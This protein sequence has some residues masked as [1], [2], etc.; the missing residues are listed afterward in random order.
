MISSSKEYVAPSW[1]WNSV[2]QSSSNSTNNNTDE[3]QE[4][5]E[6]SLE[7]LKSGQIIET[8][9]LPVN[10]GGKSFYIFGRQSDAVDVVMEHPSLSR[11]HAILQYR[12]DGALMLLDYKSAQGTYLNKE[13]VSSET[14]SR[15]YVGDMIKFGA[16][17][18]LY[19]VNGPESHRL[20]EYDSENMKLY[21]EKLQQKSKAADK[22]M[23]D[24]ISWGFQ[25]DAPYEDEGN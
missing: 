10:N 5:Q 2:S 23:N 22:Q 14:Y 6:F 13:L 19:I 1:A 20:P 7:V 18:R 25:E 15:V 3:K 11:Q 8:I 17:T 4:S 21:R 12:N 9:H 24:G 16:S